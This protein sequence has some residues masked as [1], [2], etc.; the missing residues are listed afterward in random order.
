M[1]T[2]SRR[3][4]TFSHKKLFYILLHDVILSILI[5]FQSILLPFGLSLPFQQNRH[6]P[7]GERGKTEE[8]PP[9]RHF[10]LVFFE[11]LRRIWQILKWKSVK[12]SLD[13]YKH[14]MLDRSKVIVIFGEYALDNHIW[15]FTVCCVR[16]NE[17]RHFFLIT[18]NFILM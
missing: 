10:S 6:E 2:R 7:K 9:R 1:K 17:I 14:S 4:T 8:E 18:F 16:W 13:Q 5:P 3:K 11:I 15:P 12:M